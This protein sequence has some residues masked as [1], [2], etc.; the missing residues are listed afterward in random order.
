MIRQFFHNMLLRRHFWRYATFS[1]IAEIYTSRTLR[2][3]AINLA[4]AMMS[5]Y[6][7]QNGYNVMFIAG[8]WAIYY[9]LKIF[10][11]LPSAKFIAHYGPKH[12]TLLS[13]LLYIPALVSFTF[14]PEYGLWPM[15]ITCVLQGLSATIYDVSYLINFSKVKSVANAG[16]EIAYM[17]IFEKLAT[18]LSPLLG[19]VVALFFV[20]EAT[21]YAASFLFLVASIPLLL[22]PEPTRL[23]QKLVIRGFVWRTTWRSLAA[24]AAIGFDI[25][26][27]GTVWSLLVAIAILGVTGDEVYAKLG[28]LLTVVLLAALVSSYV[29]GKLIDRRRGGELLRFAVI[30]KALT[31]LLRPFITSIGGAVGINAANEAASTGYAMAFTRGLFD[32]ADTSGQRMTYMGL[33]NLTANIGACLSA[34]MVMAM[35]VVV[36]SEVDGMRVYFVVA[37]IVTLGI[38][39]AKFRLYQK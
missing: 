23:K 19:G 21:M 24:E 20:P 39:T 25:V 1:E 28:G 35:I 5:V 6:L 29:Y 8:Y 15:A 31:H 10:M 12:A 36:G 13:N 37:A 16:K 33:V 4:A 18:G 34:L 26:A 2:T 32:T 7:Y 30:G 3:M 22:S 38:A 27:S 9:F 11:S 14:V 17:N